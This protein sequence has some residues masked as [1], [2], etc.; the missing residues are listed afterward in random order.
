[1]A[2]AFAEKTFIYFFIR[3]LDSAF[4]CLIHADNRL[5]T[6][7]FKLLRGPAQKFATLSKTRSE[8]A[9]TAAGRPGS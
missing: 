3:L 6:G 9:V 5:L 1:F 2:L 8:H 7:Q 4:L